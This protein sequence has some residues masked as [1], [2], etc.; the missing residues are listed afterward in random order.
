MTARVAVVGASGF[1][2][3][4]VV[5]RLRQRCVES[6]GVAGPRVSGTL[7]ATAPSDTAVAKVAD[8]L[9]G[10]TCVINAA[11]LGEATAGSNAELDGA[12]GLMPGLLARACRRHGVRLIHV[13]S[14]AVQ[15][16]LP[17]DSSERYAAFSP[18][19]RSKVIG[20][21][22]VLATP[23]EVCVVRPPGVHSPTRSVTR[24]IIALAGSPFSTVAAP[25]N[26]NAPQAQLGNVADAIA[27][28]AVH[29]GPIP[30]IVHLPAEGISTT[31]LLTSLGGRAPLTI[32]RIPARA[33]ITA[34]RSIGTMSGRLAGNA[35][36]LEVLWFGQ[37]QARSWL[38][39]AGWSPPV[40]TKGWSH[41][42]T[43]A[44]REDD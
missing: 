31:D 42:R 26:D 30:R 8:T 19:S 36:R 4:A 2:G 32:P 17:L 33:A 18:Y 43:I 10:A 9:A 37:P 25:G 13:S 20:E 1:V 38:T 15:G 44:N 5:E 41:M 29:S 7:G 16:R 12:N 21:Q 35:R 6:F 34:A 11:G 24:S 39:D 40:G 22:A 23:G 14:A 28:L 3:S 27:F